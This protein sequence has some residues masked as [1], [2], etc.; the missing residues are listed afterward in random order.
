MLNKFMQFAL[1]ISHIQISASN[2]IVPLKQDERFTF[3]RY[4]F[5]TNKDQEISS[6]EECLKISDYF[7]MTPKGSLTVCYVDAS[8]IEHD[9]ETDLYKNLEILFGINMNKKP[10]ST[11]FSFNQKNLDDD[12]CSTV[13]S[14]VHY[15]TVIQYTSIKLNFD[16]IVKDKK[17]LKS[18]KE[19]F[20][21]ECLSKLLLY[22]DNQSKQEKLLNME[23]RKFVKI[24]DYFNKCE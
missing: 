12:R 9:K 11:R 3:Y 13:N 18:F 23:T 14:I 22:Y 17:L 21:K 19:H 6:A 24:E 20:T 4:C 2:L 7:L 16:L 10:P 8:T 1:I 15:S 5:Y